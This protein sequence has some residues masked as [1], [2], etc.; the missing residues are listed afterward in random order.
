MAADLSTTKL[1]PD[2][3]IL[4]VCPSFLADVDDVLTF[5]PTGPTTPAITPRTRPAK[6]SKHPTLC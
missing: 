5:A 2:S 6:L 1:N 4:L 3:H